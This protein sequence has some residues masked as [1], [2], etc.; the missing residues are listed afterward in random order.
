MEIVCVAV[1]GAISVG[2][3][4]CVIAVAVAVV[5]VVILSFLFFALCFSMLFFPGVFPPRFLSSRL[6]AAAIIRSAFSISRRASPA[7][8]IAA[9][10]ASWYV[11]LALEYHAARAAM[12]A[13]MHASS[14]ILRIS[15]FILGSLGFILRRLRCCSPSRTRSPLFLLVLGVVRKYEVIVFVAVFWRLLGVVS[16]WVFSVRCLSVCF[17]NASLASSRGMPSATVI[18]F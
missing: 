3:V 1:T 5:G 6:A 18:F 4:L 15:G 14:A 13:T 10:V 12:S 7:R 8:H 9:R 2:G 11:I 16:C 17:L